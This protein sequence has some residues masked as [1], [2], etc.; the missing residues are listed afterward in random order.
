[1][2]TKY[3]K[4]RLPPNSAQHHLNSLAGDMNSL[5]WKL[6]QIEKR[7]PSPSFPADAPLKL[8]H[9]TNLDAACNIISS[10]QM[11]A[12]HVSYL[13]DISERT[14]GF[15]WAARFIK[16]LPNFQYFQLLDKLARLTALST[17]GTL[18]HEDLY[19]I[20][21]SS[22]RD[23]T[24]QWIKYSFGSAKI[25]LCFD[26]TGD[27]NDEFMPRQIVYS[28]NIQELLMNTLLM[29]TGATLST[30]IT[31]YTETD[32]PIRLILDE[33]NDLASRFKKPEWSS[34]EEWRILIPGNRSTHPLNFRVRGTE[35]VPYVLVEI[36]DKRVETPSNLR[37]SEVM[38]GPTIPGKG[39]EKSLR[40]MLDAYGFP[41]VQI[42]RSN[43]SLR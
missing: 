12:S 7:F 29:E 24:D 33:C 8:Y 1:M 17:E 37:L 25:C 28:P 23:A 14:Y 20:S 42:S 31:Q 21:F 35:L 11:R 9:Y 32:P 18:D 27:A 38:V 40:M 19:L 13:N 30:R 3:K 2:R 4:Y 5:L 26:Y 10:R 22:L 15:E 16:S 43:S 6:E 36:N 39:T 41:N 34:E